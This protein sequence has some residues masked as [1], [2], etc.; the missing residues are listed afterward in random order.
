MCWHTRE[1]KIT[2]IQLSFMR[3][4]EELQAI[5]LPDAVFDQHIAPWDCYNAYG[6]LKLRSYL[7]DYKLI[8]KRFEKEFDYVFEWLDIYTDDGVYMEEDS[9]VYRAAMEY[10]EKKT[11]TL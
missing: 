10:I 5:Q 7:V 4:V 9:E 1:D 11:Y 2:L 8:V 6:D 3:I